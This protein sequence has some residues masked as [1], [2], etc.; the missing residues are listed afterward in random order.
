M[1][2]QTSA[3]LLLLL[4][5][6]LAPAVE[7]PYLVK[8]L[9]TDARGAYGSG[10]SNFVSAGDRAYFTTESYL[11]TGYSIWAMDD[12]GRNAAHRHLSRLPALLVRQGADSRAPRRSHVLRRAV[13]G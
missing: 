2:R 12:D 7:L 4:G 9:N 8:D 11:E 10:P 13:P 1:R 3:F 5:A 6:A